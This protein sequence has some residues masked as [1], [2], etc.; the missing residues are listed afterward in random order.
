MAARE[1]AGDGEF[2]GFD[3]ADDDLANLLDK[4][5]DPIRHLVTSNRIGDFAKHNVAGGQLRGLELPILE[6]EVG[7]KPAKFG[8][9]WCLSGGRLAAG[10]ARKLFLA[11]AIARDKLRST[12]LCLPSPRNE[13]PFANCTRAAAS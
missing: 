5:R 7:L 8:R 12:A 10:P 3:L 2:N 11:P 1:Q 6:H 9:F 4:R 13:S